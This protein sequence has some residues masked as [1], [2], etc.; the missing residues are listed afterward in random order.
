MDMIVETDIG[1]DPDDFFALCYLHS[2]GVN[3]RAILI[4]PGDPDQV[5]IARFFC[6]QVGLHCPIGASKLGRAKP[7]SGSIHHDLMK[8]YGYKLEAQPTGLGVDILKDVFKDYPH[9]E[10]FIIGPAASLG[11]WL[12]SHP[13]QFVDR[14]TMQGGFC[15]YGLH[16][17]PVRRLP[18]F[19]GKTWMPTFNLN[20]DRPGGQAFLDAYIRER[21]FVGK[22]VCHTVVYER[23]HYEQ[24]TTPRCRAAE[25]FM[26]GMGLYLDRHDGKKFHDPTA[27]VCHLHPEIG[28]WLWG[29]VKKIE[30]G[31]GTV[32]H[33]TG[34]WVL[35]DIDYDKLWEHIY[36]WK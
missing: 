21:R 2:V 5:A 35:A 31:W 16:Q 9:S 26:E 32:L 24:M 14:A 30:G 12:K 6:D 3:I 27:A 1:H 34:D 36:E 25:L 8:K 19:E 7:S 20:G 15:G 23:H 17:Y 28:T 29:R 13:D 22:N 11:A 4:C 33:E 18:Q 10:L